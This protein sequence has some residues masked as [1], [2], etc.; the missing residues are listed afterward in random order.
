MKL[1]DFLHS[2]KTQAI[3]AYVIIIGGGL[4]ILFG[5][6][7]DNDRNRIFDIILLTA[8]FWY[9]SSKSG[10]AKDETISNLAQNQSPVV[11]NSDTT[12]LTIK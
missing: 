6:L 5:K 1:L 2:T 10:A 3:L 11:G 9:G 8:T 12:N 7:P 4:V